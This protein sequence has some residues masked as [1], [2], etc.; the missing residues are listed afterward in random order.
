MQR[1]IALAL[2]LVAVAAAAPAEKQPRTLTVTG[3][4]EISV[5]PDIC[6]ITLGSESLDKKSARTAYRMNAAL[7]NAVVAAVKAVGIEPKDLQTSRLTVQPAYRYEEKT[8]KRLFD[9]YRVT[10]QLEVKVRDLEKV[11]A[12]LDAGIE[13]GATEVN[14]VNFTVENPKRY[15]AEAR[16][17]AARAAQ[18]KAQTMA[19]VMGVKLGKPMSISESEPSGWGGYYAQTANVAMRDQSGLPDVAEL[20]P[21]E[22]K[23]T[24]TVYATY[25]I[26]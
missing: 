18:S 2:V 4:A 8:N 17:E 7:M 13:A 10:Q 6:H 20:Q 23:L 9:G 26:E 11:T 12:V 16:L 15:T 22:V 21:G 1:V 24:R 3:T 5:A 25:E 14:G 19:E